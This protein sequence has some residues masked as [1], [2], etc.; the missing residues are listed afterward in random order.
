G[1]ILCNGCLARRP[2]RRHCCADRSGC[3]YRHLLAC[4]GH[5]GTS[6]PLKCLRN[7]DGDILFFWAF[8]GFG[9]PC[10]TGPPRS[11]PCGAGALFVDVGGPL[12][13]PFC[14]AVDTK[15]SDSRL[16][17]EG[18]QVRR[19]RECL[20]CHERFTTFEMAELVMPRVINS[21]GSREPFNEEK[22]R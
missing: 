20:L 5:R 10:Y 19:R 21:N 2:E 18:H 13:C 14:S 12:H 4:N 17:A 3:K 9:W 16:V 8:T 22:L 7:I 6:H 15:G 1:G 11:C